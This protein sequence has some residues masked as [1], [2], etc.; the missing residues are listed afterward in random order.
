VRMATW[1][2]SHVQRARCGQL[3]LREHLPDDVADR[4]RLAPAEIVHDPL[5]GERRPGVVE[6]CQQL[7]QHEQL[8]ELVRVLER[9]WLTRRWQRSHIT[10]ASSMWRCR[11]FVLTR[12]RGPLG[13]FASVRLVRLF[14]L[15]VADAWTLVA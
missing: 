7:E 8:L 2:A 12:T 15:D 6:Q 11:T 14:R 10:H 13:P 9:R 5:G 3:R 1:D 4:I